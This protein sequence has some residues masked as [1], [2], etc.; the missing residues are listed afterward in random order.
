VRDASQLEEAKVKKKAYEEGYRNG[1][2]KAERRY[3]VT[4]PCSICRKIVMVSTEGKK[5]AIRKYR[6]QWRWGHKACHER[7]R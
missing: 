5:E 1:Y 3:G 7:N 2:A 6:Q 4:Y